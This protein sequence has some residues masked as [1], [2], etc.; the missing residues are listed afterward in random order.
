MN[1]DLVSHHR[2]RSVAAVGAGFFATALLSLGT[3]VV[4]HA[5]GVFPPWGQAMSDGLYVLATIYR[6]VYTLLGGYLTA[7]LAPRRPMSHVVTLGAIGLVV[8]TIGAAATWNAGPA[9]GPRWYPLLLVVTALP[10]V[11]AGGMLRARRA[12]HSM[13]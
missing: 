8:A 7:V 6:V 10:C 2:G 5:A 3:D 12:R 9:F 13:N 11:W 1:A 4:L